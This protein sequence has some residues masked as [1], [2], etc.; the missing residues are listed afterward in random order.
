M[1]EFFEKIGVKLVDPVSLVPVVSLLGLLFL[2]LAGSILLRQR[3]R[4]QPRIWMSSWMLTG[5]ACLL[6]F[7]TAP[8]HLALTTGVP[9]L[10]SGALLGLGSMQLLGNR[11]KA[12][13]VLLPTVLISLWVIGFHEVPLLALVV[14]SLVLLVLLLPVVHTMA[15][16]SWS[17][18]WLTPG[19]LA[20]TLLAWCCFLV[21]MPFLVCSEP[22]LP[23]LTAW[24]LSAA[25]H[26]PAVL[27]LATLP[28]EQTQ[29]VQLNQIRRLK[30][31]LEQVDHRFLQ[32]E[33]LSSVGLMASSVAHEL[34]NPLTAIKTMLELTL[35]H[36]QL[37]EQ[38]KHDLQLALNECNRVCRMT[39]NF[40][41]LTRQDSS[42][43]HPVQ[44]N[45]LVQA[46]TELRKYD[47]N[48][49]G[50]HTDIILQPDLPLV[51]GVPDQLL[52]VITNLIT[53]AVQ[54]M[55]QRSDS[56][57]LRIQ[58]E[59]AEGLVRVTFEDNGPGISK[60]ISARLFEPYFTTKPIGIGTGLGL[61]IS[62]EILRKHEGRLG[63]SS[64]ALGGAMFYMELPPL[65]IETPNQEKTS[66]Q[67]SISCSYP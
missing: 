43:A 27:A 53:N 2:A 30:K 25:L 48:S 38:P 49:K 50:I 40:L 63:H 57:Q 45:E 16:S 3:P 29:H 26:I 59:F 13:Q 47:F 9:L 67:S 35:E 56:R 7:F 31:Q 8:R 51:Q 58:T 41:C 10:A 14:P 36:P 42:H 39:R 44:L 17:R 20:G 15:R 19:L 55:E 65:Q 11:P 34:Q 54:A 33:R 23:R 66:P 46:A 1:T 32:S 52:Q 64:S 37:Q 24:P 22:M 18:S 62:R 6:P 61:S 60:E 5:L 28:L 12:V 4:L 21:A